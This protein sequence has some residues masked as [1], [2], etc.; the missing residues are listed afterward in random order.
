V[1]VDRRTATMLS[2][3][4]PR[5]R[6]RTAECRLPLSVPQTTELAD[7]A[8]AA[9]TTSA[10]LDPL[11][12]RDLQERPAIPVSPARMDSQASPPPMYKANNRPTKAASTALTA[13]WVPPEPMAKVAHEECEDLR[14]R[15]E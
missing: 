2:H 7:P 1:F 5:R 15:T 10:P 6:K 13:P 11:D 3:R 8:A 4:H 14:D 9:P 12:L